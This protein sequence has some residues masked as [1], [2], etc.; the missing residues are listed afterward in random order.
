MYDF[1]RFCE[2]EGMEQQTKKFDDQ[3]EHMEA[4]IDAFLR[5]YR[6]V[7][8]VIPVSERLEISDERLEELLQRIKPVVRHHDG[9]LWYIKNVHPR[10]HSFTWD[11]K[12]TTKA[13]N[14]EQLARITTYHTFA[15]PV[16]FKPS[17][18]EVLAQI[19]PRYVH[20][21]A[22]FEIPTGPMYQYI[23]TSRECHKAKT[24]LYRSVGT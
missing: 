16:F 6:G 5:K 20:A 10:R 9:E 8:R 22:A 14:L 7:K 18:A 24:T 17:V 23:K 12:V 19:P 13:G 3:R 1:G 21:T 4:A 15:A 2:L 11:P